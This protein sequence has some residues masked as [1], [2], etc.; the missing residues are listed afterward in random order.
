MLSKSQ[1]LLKGTGSGWRAMSLTV[2]THS[3]PFHADDVLAWALIRCFVDSNAE[4]IRSRDDSRIE[5]ADLVMDVGGVYDPE[6]LRFDHHQHSYQGELSSAGMVLQWLKDTGRIHTELFHELRLHL[7]RYV[8]DVDNGRV[9][10]IE[11]IP[12]FPSMVGSFNLG[13]VSQEDFNEAFLSAGRAAIGW[14][15]GL[16]AGVAQAGRNWELVCAAMSEAQTGSHNFMVLETYVKW[17][18]AY[19]ENG[20]MQHCTEFVLHPGVDGRWRVIAIP[21]E[22]GSFDKKRPLPESWAGL[23][24]E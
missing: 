18:K 12:C 4:L 5:K 7:V 20:G 1:V 6:T 22:P 23:R 15:Q 10:P 9:A 16:T 2:A 8:D 21:P 11:G 19:F 13:C 17:K 24:D 14:V 3:G